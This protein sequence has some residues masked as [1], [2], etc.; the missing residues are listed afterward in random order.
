L[1]WMSFA[2]AP[3]NTAA[4]TNANFF[5]LTIISQKGGGGGLNLL[6]KASE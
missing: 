1:F 2:Q 6:P 5:T 3:S 4:A